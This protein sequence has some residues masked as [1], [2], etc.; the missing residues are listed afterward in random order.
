MQIGAKPP[1]VVLL[2]INRAEAVF[3]FHLFGTDALGQVKISPHFTPNV[4]TFALKRQHISGEGLVGILFV[5]PI[6]TQKV[7]TK[8]MVLCIVYTEGVRGI[9]IRLVRSLLAPLLIVQIAEGEAVLLDFVFPAD[10]VQ[11]KQMGIVVQQAMLLQGHRESRYT[12]KHRYL[13]R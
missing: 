1:R 9:M 5:I 11:G 13:V 10:A 12:D 8:A 4:S 2:I 6:G 7:S 3:G